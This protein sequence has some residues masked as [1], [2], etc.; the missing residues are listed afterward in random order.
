MINKC[1]DSYSSIANLIFLS[2]LTDI[3]GCIQDRKF[4]QWEAIKLVKDFTAGCAQDGVTF[5]MGMV[6]ENKQ[7]FKGFISHL[8]SIFQSGETVSDL[9]SEFYGQA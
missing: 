9:I 5:Y 8:I 1:K 2:W 7:T 3:K 4:T 6:A